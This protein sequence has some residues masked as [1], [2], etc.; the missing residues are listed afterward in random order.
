MARFKQVRCKLDLVHDENDELLEDANFT[1]QVPISRGETV[2][3]ILP[4]IKEMVKQKINIS[5]EEYQYCK[6]YKGNGPEF[7]DPTSSIEKY[8]FL[9][10]RYD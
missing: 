2:E 9:V 5:D 10:Y 8:S 4:K 7:D 1:L 6:L 3:Q